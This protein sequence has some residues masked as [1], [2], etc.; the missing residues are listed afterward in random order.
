MSTPEYV[1]KS[2]GWVGAI[3]ACGTIDGK[4]PF[5]FRGLGR[6]GQV[7]YTGHFF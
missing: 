6:R 5:I 1:S 4:G 3:W 2:T 7:I